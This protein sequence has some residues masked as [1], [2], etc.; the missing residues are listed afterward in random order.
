[1]RT[2]GKLSNRMQQIAGKPMRFAV[3]LSALAILLSGCGGGPARGVDV[4]GPWRPI[5]ISSLDQLSGPL[6]RQI[7]AHN[8]V[9]ERLCGWQA[10]RN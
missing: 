2:F 6:G 4:C 3:M 7:V 1:M 5:Y 10:V 8:E 9:G